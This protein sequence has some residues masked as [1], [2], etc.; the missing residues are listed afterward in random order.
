M[1]SAVPLHGGSSIPTPEPPPPC[2]LLQLVHPTVPRRRRP[3][4]LRQV[5]GVLSQCQLSVAS[6]VINASTDGQICDVFRVTN[7]QGQKIPEVRRA[8]RALCY[9]GLCWAVHAVCWASLPGIHLAPR[10]TVVP[11]CL[12]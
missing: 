11:S 1:L 4:P 9:A 8:A 2:H 6:A 5:T 7:A 10:V 12:D 3:A